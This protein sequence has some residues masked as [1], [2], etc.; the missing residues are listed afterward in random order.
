MLLGKY[1]CN[2]SR[3]VA[4]LARLELIFGGNET[5]NTRSCKGEE[6]VP[7]G[8]AVVSA[9]IQYIWSHIDPKL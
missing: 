7:L 8:M 2:I 9:I 5:D 4:D 1:T 6:V 3:A